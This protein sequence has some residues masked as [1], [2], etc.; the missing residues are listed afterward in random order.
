MK[1]YIFKGNRSK[2][3][4]VAMNERDAH[5]YLRNRSNWERQDLVYKGA[6][7]EG[8]IIKK[9]NEIYRKVREK[10]GVINILDDDMVEESRRFADELLGGE[11]L[12]IYQKADKKIIPRNF[13]ILGEDGNINLN[14]KVFGQMIG[15]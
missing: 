7:E 6:V 13:D 9:N 3:D 4:Y 15:K 1:I 10:Y 11:L 12:K 5:N 14:T 8:L 2:N